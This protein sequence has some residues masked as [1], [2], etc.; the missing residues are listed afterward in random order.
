M[1][2]QVILNFDTFRA[3]TVAFKHPSFGQIELLKLTS[4]FE[5]PI[6]H[7]CGIYSVS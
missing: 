2:E 1:T 7:Y 4:D 6:L 3:C 5:L